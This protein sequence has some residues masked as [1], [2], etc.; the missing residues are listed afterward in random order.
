MRCL[1]CW[2]RMAMWNQSRIGGFVIPA[3]A[4]IDRS[5]GQ[6]SVNAVSLVPAVRPT[7]SRLRRISAAM[8][9]S[10][11]ATAP[12][13]CRPRR[14]S[15]HCRRELPDSLKVVEQLRNAPAVKPEAAASANHHHC[16]FD[17]HP[18]LSGRRT[19]RMAAQC[20]GT[21]AGL[22]RQKIRQ[23]VGDDTKGHE[24]GKMRSQLIQLRRRPTMREPPGTRRS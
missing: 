6:P 14:D 9:V 5:P 18:R 7:V 23:N 13:T 10:V 8:S 11:L 21:L 2:S 17:L 4:R 1:D 3:L 12:K 16:G 22:D 19:A 20:L 24:G 15:R